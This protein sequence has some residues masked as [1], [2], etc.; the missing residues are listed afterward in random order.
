MANEFDKWIEFLKPE[1]LKGNLISCSLYIATYKS[2]KDYVIEEVNF[3]L[4]RGSR[5]MN[6]YS[7][8]DIRPVC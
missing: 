5:E 8:P 2:F 7:V 1:N 4:I 6:S 3:F